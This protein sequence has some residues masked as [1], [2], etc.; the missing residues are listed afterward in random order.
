MT[1]SGVPIPVRGQDWWGWPIASKRWADDSRSSARREVEPCFRSRSLSKDTVTRPSADLSGEETEVPEPIG[2]L[3][4]TARSEIESLC[5]TAVVHVL[6]LGVGRQ[7]ASPGRVWRCP[8]EASGGGV[9]PGPDPFLRAEVVHSSERTRVSR[10]F[11]PGR[12]V[13][14]KEP[15][16]PDGDR[17]V[18]HEAAMLERLGG[19][20]GVVQLAQEPRYPRSVVLEDAGGA[21]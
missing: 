6:S 7:G 18:R 2:A 19:V 14:R 15:L 12:T 8:M 9:R 20:A 16:G 4:P 3:A 11:L 10:L 5:R 21:S 13:I 1:E 17:R